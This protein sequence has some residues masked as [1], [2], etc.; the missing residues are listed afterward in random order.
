MTIYANISVDKNLKGAVI[1]KKKIISML[2]I[3]SLSIALI[4]CGAEATYVNPVTGEAMDKE[5]VE[6]LQEMRDELSELEG[7]DEFEAE[8]LG[9][10]NYDEADEE[11]EEESLEE[12]DTEE[13][14]IANYL[15]KEL[16]KGSGMGYKYVLYEKGATVYELETESIPSEIKT[17]KGDTVAVIG[18]GRVDAGESLYEGN[19]KNSIQSLTIP[20]NIVFIGSCFLGGCSNLEEVII[21]NTVEA[22]DGNG[23]FEEC[24]NL[25]KVTFPE[26]FVICGEWKYTFNRC[27][28]LEKVSLP[29]GVKIISDNFNDC[30]NLTECILNDDLETIKN[31]FIR[32]ENLSDIKIPASVTAIW[33]GFTYIGVENI[34]IP[35]TVKELIRFFSIN[36]CPNLKTIEIGD[37]EY[38]EIFGPNDFSYQCESLS[39]V[40]FPKNV[41][42]VSDSKELLFRKSRLPSLTELYLPDGLEELNLEGFENGELTVY[43][44]EDVID[45]LSQKYPGVNFVAR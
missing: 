23:S 34:I 31:S 3:T 2:M 37:V 11:K 44:E 20:S 19:A 25:K 6:E 4:G 22:F 38:A 28:S 10:N 15:G 21:P 16:E 12:E 9:N 29:R 27:S 43:I 14:T 24:S 18:I 41:G 26:E 1:M 39:K 32:C 17:E 33:G 42:D 36:N 35:D 40:V 7:Y 30:N 8:V 45:F 13:I 5:E